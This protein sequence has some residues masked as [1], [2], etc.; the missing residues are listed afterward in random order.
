MYQT[1][2]TYNIITVSRAMSNRIIITVNISLYSLIL[3]LQLSSWLGLL[4][5]MNSINFNPDKRQDSNE[6]RLSQ[7]LHHHMKTLLADMT[8]PTRNRTLN[9]SA[10]NG[11]LRKG[12]CMIA[13]SEW[14]MKMFW[15]K[16]LYLDIWTPL[17]NIRTGKD[18]CIPGTIRGITG[19]LIYT[20]RARKS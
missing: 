8:I 5:Y 4:Y 19:S 7:N 12:V 17:R 1:L 11:L 2:Q 10:N 15:N 16:T 20:D 3:A 14:L 9:V 18:V 13:D 6:I